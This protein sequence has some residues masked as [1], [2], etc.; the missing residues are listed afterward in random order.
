MADGSGFEVAGNILAQI[1]SLYTV[2]LAPNS[3]TVLGVNDLDEYEAEL[4]GELFAELMGESEGVDF[5]PDKLFY[6]K[7]DESGFVAEVYT[8]SFGLNKDGTGLCAIAGDNEFPATI[9]PAGVQVGNVVLTPEVESTAKTYTRKDEKFEFFPTKL[10]GLVKISGEEFL[11]EML[12]WLDKTVGV[13]PVEIK[14][15]FRSGGEPLHKILSRPSAGATYVNLDVLGIGNYPVIGLKTI[16]CQRGDGQQYP[17]RILLLD[18]GFGV[19]CDGILDRQLQTFVPR[20]GREAIGHATEDGWMLNPGQ[21]PLYL[22]IAGIRYE[23]KT[24][25]DKTTGKDETKT[26][27]RVS[28]RVVMAAPKNFDGFSP[29]PAL[30]AEGKPIA[31]APALEATKAAL[32][33]AVTTPMVQE[34]VTET[35]TVEATVVE[36]PDLGF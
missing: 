20:K 13:K 12:V 32:A 11:I 2:D 23:E 21:A 30:D 34:T 22:E 7:A 3:K 36:Q 31:T 15:V 4:A 33:P 14:K 35:K 5:N 26:F 6:V 19:W 8:A 9:T 10:S 18:G 16:L 28:A 25:K 27:S 29:F 1:S 17:K 24:Y